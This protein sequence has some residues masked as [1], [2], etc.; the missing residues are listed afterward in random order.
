MFCAELFDVIGLLLELEQ[1]I[2]TG[3]LL[4]SSRALSLSLSNDESCQCEFNN[5]K[6]LE[7]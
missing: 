5:V 3:I 6:L 7:F 4:G 2:E 1:G